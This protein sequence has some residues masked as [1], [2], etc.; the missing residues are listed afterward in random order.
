MS[1]LEDFLAEEEARALADLGGSL[2]AAGESVLRSIDVRGWARA[3]PLLAVG[4]ASVCGIA[5][6]RLFAGGLTG[7]GRS[8]AQSG[9]SLAVRHQLFA[10]AYRAFFRGS[11]PPRSGSV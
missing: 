2:S 1:A 9:A 10:M 4:V 7:A 5:L 6:G 11:G 8:A 3:R